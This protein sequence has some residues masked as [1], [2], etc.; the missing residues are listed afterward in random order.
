MPSK[1]T[2]NICWGWQTTQCKMTSW[3]LAKLSLSGCWHGS[4]KYGDFLILG[5][6]LS[7]L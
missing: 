2:D 1:T 6:V 4:T 5:T 3:F 7:H